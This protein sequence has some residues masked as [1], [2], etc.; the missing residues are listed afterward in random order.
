MQR[1]FCVCRVKYFC[2]NGISVLL[3]TN[4]KAIALVKEVNKHGVVEE[5]ANLCFVNEEHGEDEESSRQE[6]YL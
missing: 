4:V 3:T 2:C 5:A 6:N 1:S